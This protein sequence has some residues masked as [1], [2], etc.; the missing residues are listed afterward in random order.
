M[1][2]VDDLMSLFN[3]KIQSVFEL[4]DGSGLAVTVARYETPAHTDIDKVSNI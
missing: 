1:K 3:R 2:M 4:S